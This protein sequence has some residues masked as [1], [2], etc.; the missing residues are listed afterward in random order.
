VPG[1]A[2]CKNAETRSGNL[3]VHESAVGP[4][5]TIRCRAAIRLLSE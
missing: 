4:I 1:F 3:L 5:A 2:E